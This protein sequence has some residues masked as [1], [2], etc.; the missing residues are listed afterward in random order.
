MTNLAAQASRET[1]GKPRTPRKSRR[2]RLPG[3]FTCLLGIS[4]GL[5]LSGGCN[6]CAGTA[7][8]G[9]KPAPAR[10]EGAAHPG[11][12]GPGSAPAAPSGTAPGAPKR[13]AYSGPETVGTGDIR[14][15]ALGPPP[16][17]AAKVQGAPFV[18]V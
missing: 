9:S 6:G 1:S 15:P 2:P 18:L 11:K 16:L 10:E 13:P 3:A 12:P 5:G 14:E 8:R 4:V 7:D 17:E